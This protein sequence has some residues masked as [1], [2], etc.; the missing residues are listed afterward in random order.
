MSIPLSL[1][2]VIFMGMLVGVSLISKNFFTKDG[3][4]KGEQFQ[5]SPQPSLTSDPSLN[6]KE[7]SNINNVDGQIGILPPSPKPSAVSSPSVKP[8]ESSL[9]LSDFDYPNSKETLND[10]VT[11]KLESSDNPENITN[12]YKEKIRSLGMNA[13]SFVTTKT[14]DNVLNKLAGSGSSKEIKVEISKKSNESLT[15]IFVTVN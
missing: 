12:W 10:G 1:G 2:L 8:K 3:K 15:T 7:E 14:N 5:Q 4:I 11:L 13:K 9:N 6:M